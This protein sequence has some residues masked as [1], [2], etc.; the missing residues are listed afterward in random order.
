MRSGNISITSG[1]L[2]NPTVDTI[3]TEQSFEIAEMVRLYKVA[4]TELSLLS[5]TSWA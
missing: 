2:V 4:R 1:N 5:R 3:E